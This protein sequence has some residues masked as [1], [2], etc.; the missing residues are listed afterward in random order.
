MAIEE[1]R[2]AS[3]ASIDDFLLTV[4]RLNVR[5]NL[6]FTCLAAIRSGAISASFP[7][8]IAG[9]V[10]GRS[11]DWPPEVQRAIADGAI[12]LPG[13]VADEELAWL[14]GHCRAFLFFSRGE[15]FGLP[16]LEALRAG[17]EVLASDIP[18]MREIL[19]EHA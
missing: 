1:S 18:V 5:K 14:Y 12:I 11:E 16:P 15:G 19:G 2:P 8:V 13:Y 9:S 4:G 6:A 10:H 17:G 3:L 7:L